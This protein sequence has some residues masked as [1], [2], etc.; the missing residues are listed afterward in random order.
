[1]HS[2]IVAHKMLRLYHRSALLVPVK[3]GLKLN[4]LI[5]KYV[6]EDGQPGNH[7]LPAPGHVDEALYTDEEDVIIQ[8]TFSGGGGI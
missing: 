1:M 2:L 8:R 5:L 6:Q 3:L 7:R 4:Y